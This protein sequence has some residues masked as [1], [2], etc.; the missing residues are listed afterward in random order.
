[1]LFHLQAVLLWRGFFIP[2]QFA[3]TSEHTWSY[4]RS[5]FN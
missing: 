3:I 5:E 1:V 2:F 4:F